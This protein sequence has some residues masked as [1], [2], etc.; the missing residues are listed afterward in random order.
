MQPQDLCLQEA[1]SAPPPAWPLPVSRPGGHGSTGTLHSTV[2]PSKAG[3]GFSRGEWSSLSRCRPR[4]GTPEPEGGAEGMLAKRESH[5][6]PLHQ[7]IASCN[8]TKSLNLGENYVP[9]LWQ[10]GAIYLRKRSQVP[11]I[12]SIIFFAP[13]PHAWDPYISQFV[14]AAVMTITVDQRPLSR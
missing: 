3:S 7:T 13:V 9:S 5:S 2:L 4:E 1:P 6:G 10:L 14:D 12:V 11:V 8:K